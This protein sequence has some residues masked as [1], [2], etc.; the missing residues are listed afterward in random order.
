MLPPITY[1]I[2]FRHLDGSVDQQDFIN[3]DAAWEAF[4]LFAEPRSDELYRCIALTEINWETHFNTILC[5]LG[6]KDTFRG[7]V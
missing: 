5:V 1:E 2:T 4:R 6:F 7:I 3:A